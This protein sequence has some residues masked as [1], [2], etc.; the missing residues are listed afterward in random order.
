MGATDDENAEADQSDAGPAKRR[1]ILTENEIAKD[2]NRSIGEG[3]RGLDIAVVRPGEEQHVHQK[4]TEKTS[5]AE[6]ESWQE[7]SMVDQG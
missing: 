6:P 5:D 3:R 2:G 7:K 1:D 4:K